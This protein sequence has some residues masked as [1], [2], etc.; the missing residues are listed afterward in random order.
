M[1]VG[2]CL[3]ALEPQ[4]WKLCCF[5]LGLPQPSC[6]DLGLSSPPFWTPLLS[7]V[8][9]GLNSRSWISPDAYFISLGWFSTFSPYFLLSSVHVL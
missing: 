4:V 9:P 2:V 7:S 8:E 1:W 6:V 5:C 3:L